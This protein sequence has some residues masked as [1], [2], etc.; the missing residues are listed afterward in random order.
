MKYPLGAA[1]EPPQRGEAAGPSPG[2]GVGPTVR[3]EEVTMSIGPVQVIVLGFAE[4]DFKGDALK[5]LE[6]LRENDVVRMIDLLVVRKH[7]DGTVEQLHRSDLSDDEKREFGAV[8]GGLMGYAM[9]G[10][11]GAEIGAEAGAEA[12]AE[13]GVI[14]DEEVFYLEEM[15]RPGMAAAVAVIEHRW[16]IDLRDKLREAGGTLLGDAWVHPRDLVA[17]GIIAAEE[18]AA[19]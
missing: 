11:E 9:A 12:M 13:G 19:H 14:G 7:D 18:A 1:P 2:E 4:P 15:I 16:A 6:R 10:A 17:V 3:P 5:E 8:A